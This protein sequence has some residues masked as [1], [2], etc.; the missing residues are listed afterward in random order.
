MSESLR[1]QEEALEAARNASRIESLGI[2]RFSGSSTPLS[3]SLAARQ[4]HQLTPARIE[5]RAEMNQPYLSHIAT[6][7]Q[8]GITSGFMTTWFTIRNF[9]SWFMIQRFL[10][11]RF[12]PIPRKLLRG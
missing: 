1:R 7:V 9:V 4:F 10:L 8:S 11:R 6:P 2:G 5:R 3:E 12:I